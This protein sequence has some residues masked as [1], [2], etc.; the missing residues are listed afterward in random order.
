MPTKK[1]KGL[2]KGLGNMFGVKSVADVL[3]P[4]KLQA[5]NSV[6]PLDVIVAGKHQART[7]FDA[8]SLKELASSI[9]EKGVLNPITVRE[10]SAG[11]YEI[12]A[13][14]R[15]YRASKQAGLKEVPVTILNVD[16][17]QALTI[18]LI[19]NLQREDLNSIEAA[20][21]IDHLIKDFGYS[22]EQAAQAIGRSRSMVTNLLRLLSLPQEIQ[23]LIED[24]Q[25]DMGHARA[26]LTLNESEQLEISR[27]ICE[28]GLSVRQTEQLVA[29][30]KEEKRDISDKREEKSKEILK[31]EKELSGLLNA[32][33][34]LTANSRG[35]G[36]L[37]ISFANKEQFER[38]IERL[39]G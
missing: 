6:L 28:K 23:S 34:S 24:G 26:L 11:K 35:K 37:L 2:G 17:E 32:K 39:R 8:A 18:G 5:N 14:E 19:E 38:I 10:I 30:L 29:K 12:L 7:V 4:K 15:R 13:G 22:H 16:D 3:D 20:K 27:L 21:G 31:F 36:K 9:K 25:L 33:V 1:T